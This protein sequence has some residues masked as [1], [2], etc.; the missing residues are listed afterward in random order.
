MFRIGIGQSM[1]RVDPALQLARVGGDQ[2]Q[3]FRSA[4]PFD[5]QYPEY[6]FDIVGQAAEAKNALGRISDDAAG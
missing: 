2:D 1:V 4:S 6:G 3:P 5:L